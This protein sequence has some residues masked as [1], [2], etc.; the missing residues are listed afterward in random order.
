MHDEGINLKNSK[1]KKP[2]E[3][4]YVGRSTLVFADLIKQIILKNKYSTLLDYGSG[5]GNIYFNK[6]N[7]NNKTYP[8]LKDYWNIKE[9]L[10]DPGINKFKKPSKNLFDITISIDVLEHIPT[11]DLNWVINEI[12]QFSKKAV[13]I[14]VACYPAVALLPN[15]HNA[16][17]SVFDPSWWFNLIYSIANEY[18]LKVFLICT[19]KNP[20]TEY[21]NYCINDN[22][23][24]YTIDLKN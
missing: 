24:N 22:F 4:T 23:D 3:E 10:Y 19:K 14:N 9:T 2:P 21:Y 16:H 15:G 20:N 11:Q 6:N 7:Y 8:P 18:K 12:F 5:K 13:F 17:V 1:E